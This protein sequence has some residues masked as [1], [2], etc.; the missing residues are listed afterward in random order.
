MYCKHEREIKK[1]KHSCQIV[2]LREEEEEEEMSVKFRQ[3]HVGLFIMR[4]E[5]CFG[6]G[7]EE[8]EP[9]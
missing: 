2:F 1:K 7:G 6:R 9:G 5:F 4:E 3:R 8:E